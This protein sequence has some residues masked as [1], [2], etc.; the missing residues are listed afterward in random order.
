MKRILHFS[1]FLLIFLLLEQ[2]AGAQAIIADHN[3]V[4]LTAIPDEALSPAS[5]LR[6]HLRRASVG[7][8]IDDG[9]N[10]IQIINAKYDRSHWVFYD[11]GNP[12]WEAKIS[13][14]VSFT[15]ANES[16]Y[17]VFSMKFCFI[18][19]DAD[20][21]CYRDS[22][23]YLENRYPNKIIV[24]WTI[25]IETSGNT[26][27]QLFNDSVRAYAMTH[28]KVLFDMA[29]IE[30][31]NAAGTKLVDGSN[32]E[33]MWSEWTSDGGHLNTIGSQR[34]ASA[35]WWLMARVAGWDGTINTVPADRI[36]PAA[37]QNLV[38]TNSSSQTITIK[39]WKNTEVDFLRYRI[40]QG[41]SP[42]PT[43]KVDS[44]MGGIADTAKI[45][46][47]LVDGTR[48]YFRVTAV[49][50]VG[51]ESGYS[52]EVNEVPADRIAPA[53]PQNLVV[54]D[55][56][57]H[58]ITI[59]WRMNT[60]E[61]FMLYRI[62]Q[63]ASPNPNTMVNMM[64]G[65]IADTAKTFTGL[66][67]GTRYYFRVTAV[68]NVGNESGY[69]NEV[70]AVPQTNITFMDGSWYTAPNAASNTNNNPVG[71]FKLT[72]DANGATLTSVSVTFSGSFS[73]VTSMKLW[74]S[75]DSIFGGD[76]RLD[77]VTFRSSPVTLSGSALTIDTG[78]TYYFVTVDL[79]ASKGNITATIAIN[80]DITLAAG[81][82]TGT[83]TD[84]PLANNSAIITRVD[85]EE[86]LALRVFALSQNYPNPF[87]PTTT[88][89]FSLAEKSKVLLKVYN[90][91]GQEVATLLDGE[92]QAGILHRVPFNAS[93]LSSGIYFYRLETKDNV[94]LKKLVLMK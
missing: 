86:Q 64:M 38:V 45:F 89:E 8:N 7:G 20:F 52:N 30:S 16:N 76:S 77:S 35:W 31:H 22:L 59:K 80:A 92:M 19:P 9:L 54:T 47:G 25:P 58:T 40:Y 2:I 93:R 87:N 42:N 51:N 17:A 50:N 85:N 67:D 5:T 44:M 36:A 12:G 88:I 4:D 69:S 3:T 39:W 28:G 21:H 70:N 82:L 15:I 65:D 18:D 6:V 61:D 68:D 23:L 84:V 94:Q 1:I 81:T 73:G 46:I 90:V 62:Y 24:W 75:A 10:A 71:R 33:L 60:E 72:A 29:D 37:P 53:A 26:N 57:S 32:R 79:V 13:D 43:I 41:T 63:G 34:V 49:D 91:L 83:I 78:G 48:Y 27:R 55:S 14:F 66:V 11:R 74:S 56:S